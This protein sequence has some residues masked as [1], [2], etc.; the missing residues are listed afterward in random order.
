MFPCVINMLK[1]YPYVTRL[2][3]NVEYR[4]VVCVKIVLRIPVVSTFCIGGNKIL[5]VHNI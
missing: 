3:Y 4:C 5:V 2:H 1:M